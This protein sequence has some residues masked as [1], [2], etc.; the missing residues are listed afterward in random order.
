MRIIMSAPEA[1][2]PEAEHQTH[3]Y[4]GNRI[5]W[6][7]HLIWVLFWVLAVYYSLRYIL[8]AIQREFLT[9]PP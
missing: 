9:P 3:R 7:V 5:P 1:N 2:T 8:P 6:Y 4:I